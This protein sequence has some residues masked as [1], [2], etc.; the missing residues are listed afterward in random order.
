MAIGSAVAVV[1]SRCHSARHGPMRFCRGYESGVDHVFAWGLMV[2]GGWVALADR[3]AVPLRSSRRTSSSDSS[4]MTGEIRTGG[5][6]LGWW[7]PW[8]LLSPTLIILI[9]FLY[10]PAI[11]TFTLSTKLTKLGAPKVGRRLLLQLHGTCSSQTRGSSS[12]IH[13]WPLPRST[14]PASGSIALRPARGAAKGLTLLPC[15]RCSNGLRSP[16]RHVFTRG[17]RPGRVP[18]RVYLNTVIITVGIVAFGMIGG[19]AVAYL[20]FRTIRGGSVY[21]TLLIWPYAISPAV[22]GCP[23]LHDL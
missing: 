15:S 7:V 21:R 17:R 8:A 20:A 5:F 13:S 4:A 10:L 11:Q 18:A 23:L 12:R 1:G 9:I 3:S 6:R 16:V 14:G 22:A 19:L 2:G